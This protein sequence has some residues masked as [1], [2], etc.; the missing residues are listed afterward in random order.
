MHLVEYYERKSDIVFEYDH[1]KQ[2]R[3]ETSAVILLSILLLTDLETSWSS[4]S[5]P[6]VGASLGHFALAMHWSVTCDIDAELYI[7][8]NSL[9][10]AQSIVIHLKMAAH[11]YDSATDGRSPDGLGDGNEYNLRWQ[12]E[13]RNWQEYQSAMQIFRCEGDEIRNGYH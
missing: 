2:V 10:R 3:V 7:K 9:L 1:S 12:F 13:V 6:T 5:V 4:G 8:H 11:F